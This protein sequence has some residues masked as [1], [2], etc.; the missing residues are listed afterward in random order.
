M[1]GL[2]N[3]EKALNTENKFMLMCTHI[4]EVTFFH[5]ENSCPEP[6]GESRD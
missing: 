5:K 6:L 1:N 3:E 2:L 4:S